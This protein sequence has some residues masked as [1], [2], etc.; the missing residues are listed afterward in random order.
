MSLDPELLRVDFLG[1]TVRHGSVDLDREALALFFATAGERHGLTR[2]DLHP[3][4]GATL[5]CALEPV[6]DDPTRQYLRLVH[7]QR[8]GARHRG[9]HRGAPGRP[10]LSAGPAQPVPGR[11]RPALSP[12]R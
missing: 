1:A 9:P 12:A 11:R 10:R 2:L 7:S 3:D 8:P 6:H 5:E 4:E